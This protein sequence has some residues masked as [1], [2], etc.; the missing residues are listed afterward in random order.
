[1]IYLTNL[2]MG[3]RVQRQN[4]VNNKTEK[5]SKQMEKQLFKKLSLRVERPIFKQCKV[6]TRK[7]LYKHHVTSTQYKHQVLHKSVIFIS[8]VFANIC[9]IFLDIF[10]NV[11]G[12]LIVV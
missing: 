6:N 9:I 4:T 12:L 2:I 10:K 5:E 1:M 8:L 3:T 7:G 11:S